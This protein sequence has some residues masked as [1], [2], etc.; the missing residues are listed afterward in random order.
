MSI[1]TLSCLVAGENPYENAFNVKVNKTEAVSELKDVIKE[2]QKPFFDNVAPKELKLW[3]VDISLEEE[4]EK[5]TA[6][7]T[8]INVNIKEELGGVELLPLSKISKHF[9]SQPADE[10]IHIIVQRP[11]ETKEVHC[12]ATYGLSASHM[13]HISGWD[14]GRTYC[15]KS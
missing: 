2:N 7:N 6:V 13:F 8:K 15:Y 10:H 5:L 14:R 11:V 4:N 3:K 12:T 1:I 9:P